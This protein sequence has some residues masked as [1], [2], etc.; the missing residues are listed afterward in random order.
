LILGTNSLTRE[1][2][3]HAVSL[4]VSA[5]PWLRCHNQKACPKFL[6]ICKSS[7]PKW[8]E[9]GLSLR[10]CACANTAQACVVSAFRPSKAASTLDSKSSLARLELLLIGGW[11][12][13]WPRKSTWPCVRPPPG[14]GLSLRRTF[15]CASARSVRRGV[16]YV[17]AARCSAGHASRLRLSAQ[18][19]TPTWL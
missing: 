9:A 8:H 4:A 13:R 5:L 17:V 12:T 10:I 2:G 6:A 15:C 1:R 3:R 14:F 11:D 7:L 18:L 19:I 16:H